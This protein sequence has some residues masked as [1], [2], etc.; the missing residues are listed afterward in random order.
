MSV[1]SQ[2]AF[3][4][5][6]FD[7]EKE[8]LIKLIKE[9]VDTFLGYVIVKFSEEKIIKYMEA[10]FGMFDSLGLC[11]V[12]REN[13]TFNA[14]RVNSIT[15]MFNDD[16]DEL[17]HKKNIEF[18]VFNLNSICIRDGQLIAHEDAHGLFN[19]IF[20][21]ELSWAKLVTEFVKYILPMIHDYCEKRYPEVYEERKNKNLIMC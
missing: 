14:R 2:D 10:S 13:F 15:V 3:C 5:D 8:E 7:I 9:H 16:V 17:Y 18:V 12:L 21:S 4:K 11:E 20:N 6:T 19:G 1:K